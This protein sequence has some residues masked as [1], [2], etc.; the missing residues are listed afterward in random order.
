M[1]RKQTNSIVAILIC[2]TILFTVSC[3]MFTNSLLKG[4]ARD[5]SDIMKNASTS[6]LLAAGADPDVIGD[7]AAAQAAMEALAE[8]DLSNISAEEASNVCSLAS[9]AI[10]PVS[11][12]MD[13]ID[14]IKDS[15]KDDNS[16]DDN[17]ENTDGSQT[18]EVNE[19]VK[20]VSEILS[21]IPAVDTTAIEQVLGNDELVKEAE[22]GSVAMATVSLMASSL[23]KADLSPERQQEQLDIISKKISE[24]KPEDIKDGVTTDV[25][26]KVLEGT[27]FENDTAM[28]TAVKAALTLKNRDD[29]S[30]LTIGGFNLGEL[31]GVKDNENSSN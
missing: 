19:S 29:I 13:A 9:S 20:V 7:P 15:T 23:S 25:I 8:K 2:L 27:A 21:S 26:D 12:L 14:K 31:I 24:I 30:S 5:M 16:E 10:L 4:A 18:E 1:K 6:E 22:I 28:K 3:D 17:S 11:T